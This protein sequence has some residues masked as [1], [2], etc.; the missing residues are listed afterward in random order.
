MRTTV[1]MALIGGLLG[2]AGC[3]EG[4][5]PP[6]FKPFADNK[7]LMQAIMDPAADEIWDSV[8]WVITVEGMEE[9]Q[10]KNEEDWM[11]VR[12]AAVQVIESGN[13]LMMPPRVM[14]GE[15]WNRI[16]TGI[17]DKGQEILRAVDSKDKERLFTL[18]GELYDVCTNC[19]AKY[20]LEVSG[21][22]P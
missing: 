12:N 21:V 10:P 8:G 18:G 3:T 19:H 2:C 6:P 15:D 14:E 1:R 7:L 20:A 11:T 22:R 9:I 13:L 5:D 16:S 17:I 4:P